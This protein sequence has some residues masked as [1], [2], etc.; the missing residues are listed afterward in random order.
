MEVVETAR[1]KN[2]KEGMKCQKSR[3][4]KAQQNGIKL[5]KTVKLVTRS[6]VED[7]FCQTNRQKEKDN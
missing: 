7:T 4:K 5:P 2:D 6:K 3:Q 1:K